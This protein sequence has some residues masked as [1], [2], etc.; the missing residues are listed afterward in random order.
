MGEKLHE[1]AFEHADRFVLVRDV[2]PRRH[3]R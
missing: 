2:K 3:N 1:I